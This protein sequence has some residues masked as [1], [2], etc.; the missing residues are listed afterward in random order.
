MNEPIMELDE[1]F[2]DLLQE[3]AEDLCKKREALTGIK[4]CVKKTV[5][6]VL[7]VPEQND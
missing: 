6:N 1:E 3:E 7:V 4:W 5:T 2:N